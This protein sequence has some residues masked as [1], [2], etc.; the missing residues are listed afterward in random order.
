MGGNNPYY[1]N[2]L[3]DIVDIEGLAGN[4]INFTGNDYD[5]GLAGKGPIIEYPLSTYGNPIGGVIAAQSTLSVVAHFTVDSLTKIDANINDKAY[6]V[7]DSNDAFGIWV[8]S[9]GKVN[10]SVTTDD[11]TKTCTLISSYTVPV[12]NDIPTNVILTVDTSLETGNVKLYVNGKLEDQ[13]GRK[14]TDG[15]VNNWKT[16]QNIEQYGTLRIGSEYVAGGLSK[17]QFNGKLEEITIYNIPIYPINPKDSKVT[18]YKPVEELTGNSTIAAGR[19]INAKLFVKDYH[20]I[21]GTTVEEVAQT[22]QISIKKS[23]LGLKTD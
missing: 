2:T 14:T 23:G 10:A 6:I 21:R 4:C 11:A 15:S 7:D 3:T 9:D 17:N 1:A 20:N 18:I 8:D 22:S 13:T 16:A 12:A 5:G 19:P